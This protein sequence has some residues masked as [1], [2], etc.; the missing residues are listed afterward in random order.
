VIRFDPPGIGLGDPAGQV[1]DLED[2]LEVLEDLID[3]LELSSCDLFG[4]SQAAR[5]MVA[6][7][8]RHPERVG[9]LVVFGATPT[10]VR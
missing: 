10:A 6:Y 3:G 1:I 9:R 8:A 2:D 7:A 4:A 5:V